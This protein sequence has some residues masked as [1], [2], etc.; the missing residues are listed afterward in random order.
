MSKAAI[1]KV[2]GPLS[3]SNI[4]LQYKDSKI[5]VVLDATIALGPIGLNLLGFGLGVNI[6]SILSSN[7]DSSDFSVQLRGMAAALDQPPILLAG[8]FE[9]LSTPTMELFAGGIA[10]GMDEYNFLAL[11]SYGVVTTPSEKFKTFFLFAQLHGPL[12]E[13]EFGTINGVSLGFGYDYP[14]LFFLRSRH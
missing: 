12:V 11:G 5:I 6:A 2:I 7:I 13:L 8:L 3:L 1:H 14:I 10:V 4:G 9:D